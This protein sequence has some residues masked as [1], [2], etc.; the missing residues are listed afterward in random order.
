MGCKNYG[1]VVR[2]NL[3]SEK[4]YTPYCGSGECSYGKPRTK[5]MNGQSIKNLSKSIVKNGRSRRRFYAGSNGR[6]L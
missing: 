3:M 1:S 2:N 6:K 4:Y 5:W